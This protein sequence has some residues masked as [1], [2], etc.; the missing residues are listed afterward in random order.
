M[1]NNDFEMSS[2]QDSEEE[3]LELYAAG[4]LKPGLNIPVDPKKEFINNIGGLNDAL[5]SFQSSLPWSERLDIVAETAPLAPEL[6]MELTEQQQFLKAG[7]IDEV[8]LNDFKRETMFHRHA[9]T[10]VMTGIELLHKHN[11]PTHRPEDYFAEMFKSDEHMQKV[12]HALLQRKV[13]L[14]QTEKVRRIRQEKKLAKEKRVA[15]V[16]EKH[17]QKRDLNENIKKFRKGLRNDLDFLE[18]DG[19][20]KN[21]K[22][23]N[24]KEKKNLTRSQHKRKGKDAKYGFGG[25]KRG[26]KGNTKEST[27]GGSM[28]SKGKNRGSIN[29]KKRMSMKNK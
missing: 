25:K 7:K 19:S 17:K 6:S 8:A 16:Q 5:K 22:Q 9:Q 18:T 1:T 28:K 13:E 26:M 4:K 21:Q 3:L 24:S 2:D 27:F 29:K 15:A 14:E 11:I 10:A 23:E 20:K 12:R